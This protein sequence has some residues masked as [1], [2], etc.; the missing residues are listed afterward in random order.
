M[1]SSSYSQLEI[2]MYS[3]LARYNLLDC[4]LIHVKFC[5]FQYISYLSY[6]LSFLVRVQQGTCSVRS[7]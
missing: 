3:P 1:C 6:Y 7:Q 5:I 4:T 2:R